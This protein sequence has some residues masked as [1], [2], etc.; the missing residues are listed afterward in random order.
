MS[1]LESG[2]LEDGRTYTVLEEL[3]TFCPL[4]LRFW[5]AVADDQIRDGLQ[6]RAWPLPA[7]RPVVDAFQTVSNIYAF[8]WLPGLRDV[9][10]PMASVPPA[11]PPTRRTFVIEVRDLERRFLPA[12]FQVEL[13]LPQ[14][15]LFQP[16]LLG[17][18][19]T[20]TP[21]FYLFSAPT[22]SQSPGVAVVRGELVSAT[23]LA[24]VP[25]ALVRVTI[26]GQGERWGLADAG[27]R[28]AVQFPLPLLTPGFGRLFA[29]PDGAA[30]PPGPPVADR[31]W[32]ITLDLFAQPSRLAP[33]P[34]TDL[35]DLAQVFQQ[36]SVD[37][38]QVVGSPASAVADWSGTLPFSGE[39]IAAT[40]GRRQL[41]V[42]SRGS[43]L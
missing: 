31:S 11:S 33:L 16:P 12:A 5:D 36:A 3:S 18:P 32:A 22:R 14:R 42:V 1:P 9:E 39:L 30:S 23:T 13:P 38:L 40:D 26:A 34:G 41:L 19:G 6:V 24:P 37:L 21:G 17:S 29:S 4:G 35:P 43:P 10:E 8:Q 15:G 27:G 28:F 20:A 7:R 2:V 25:W